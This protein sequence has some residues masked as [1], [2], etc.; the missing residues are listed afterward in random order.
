MPEG[1][2]NKFIENVRYD[3]S[4]INFHTSRLIM[5]DDDNARWNV[6][7]DIISNGGESDFKLR[8]E[9]MGFQL[10]NDPFSYTFSRFDN[11][12]DWYLTTKGQ[13]LVFFDKYI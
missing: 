3:F 8:M 1:K 5:T 6:P 7:K 10:E 11:K 2:N 13:S 9:M 4:M 12:S